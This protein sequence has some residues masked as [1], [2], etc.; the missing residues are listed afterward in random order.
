M[1]LRSILIS[2]LAAVAALCIAPVHASADEKTVAERP[3]WL[4][5]INIMSWATLHQPEDRS[6]LEFA[7][8]LGSQV[9]DRGIFC[10]HYSTDPPSATLPHPEQTTT[11]FRQHQLKVTAFLSVEQWDPAP[12]AVTKLISTL[13]GYVDGGCDGVHLDMLFQPRGEQDALASI[14]RMRDELHQYSRAKYRRDVLFTGN[15]WRLDSPFALRAAALT[16]VVWIESW[17]KSDLEQVRVARVARSLSNS[18]MPVWYHLQPDTDTQD[19]VLKLVNLPAALFAGCLYED[20]QFLCNYKYPVPTTVAQAKPGQPTID[21]KMTYINPGWRQTLVRYAAFARTYRAYLTGTTPV[22]SVLVAFRPEEVE[23]ANGIMDELLAHGIDFNVLAYGDAPMRP[24]TA[25]TLGHYPVI[26]TP[27]RRPELN[28]LAKTAVFATRAEDVYN[29][30]VDTVQSL[31]KIGGVKNVVGRV[32]VQGRRR[33]VHLKQTGYTDGADGLQK[34]GPLT[35]TLY[36]P[37]VRSAICVS[38]DEPGKLTPAL[39]RQGN[40]VTFTIPGVTYFALVVLE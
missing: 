16:D 10:G 36:A 1:A 28:S 37:G 18:Q 27:S 34:T 21:W 11:F 4:D 19:R 29:G 6:Y 5:Q 22:S 15:V 3:W 40:Y 38:P 12:A 31:L 8:E 24:A 30:P 7:A 14:R 25:E 17:G 26:V 23:Q 39:H 33:I 13:E 32:F 9:A 20:A 35:L 2:M